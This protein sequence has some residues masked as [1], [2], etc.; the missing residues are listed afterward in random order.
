MPSLD[1]I[2]NWLIPTIVILII[3]GIFYSNPKIKSAV[4]T[5]FGWIGVLF[6]KVKEKS[7]NIQEYE[8]VYRYG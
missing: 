1:S 7:E 5:V 2:L 6:G 3:C 8:T 4:D